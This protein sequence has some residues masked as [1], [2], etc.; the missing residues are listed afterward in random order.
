[1]KVKS[2]KKYGPLLIVI[3]L[4]GCNKYKKPTE[5]DFSADM[6]RT[7][8]LGS[9]LT[10]ESGFIQLEYFEFEGEREKGDDVYFEKEFSNGLHIPMDSTV[11]ISELDFTVPQGIYKR[12][13]ISF[14]TFDDETDTQ[15]SLEVKGNYQNASGTLIPFVFKFKDTESFEIRAKN[16]DGSSII[17]D[18]DYPSFAKIILNPEH[19][20]EIVPMDDFENAETTEIDGVS[21]IIIDKDNNDDIYDLVLD[22]LDEE[23]LILISY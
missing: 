17:L 10:F 12:M 15:S 8:T 4:F 16:E 13:D 14:S 22:R 5:L 7:P 21:T 23:N 11:N 2:I 20:F 19:W 1:M 6:S 9:K 3:I 18:E